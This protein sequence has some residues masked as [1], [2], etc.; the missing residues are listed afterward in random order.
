MFTAAKRNMSGRWFE[1]HLKAILIICGMDKI[2]L[3]SVLIYSGLVIVESRDV[4]M[5]I[6]IEIYQSRI[7]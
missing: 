5:A 7:V 6:V 4:G 3:L 2:N 1:I